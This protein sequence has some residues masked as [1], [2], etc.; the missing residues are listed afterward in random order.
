MK[1]IALFAVAVIVFF[2][3]TETAQSQTLSLQQILDQLEATPEKAGG[4]HYNYPFGDYSVAKPPKG[5]EP[6][7]ISH[8]G[9]H[10]ARYIT[11]AAKYDHA[12][13]LL[14]NGHAKGAL[15][16]EGEMLYSDYMAIY[17]LLQYHNGDLTVKGQEQHRELARRMIKA[18]P[19]L[20]KKDA[21]VDARASISPRAIVS[22]MSFCDEIHQ[23]RPRVSI[24]YSADYSELDVT[25]LK[26][27]D[28]DEDAYA[29]EFYSLFRNEYFGGSYAKAV[30][31]I[32][33]DAD[34]FFLRYLKDMDAVKE[35]GN[36]ADLFGELAEIAYNIQCL[37][38]EADLARYF[39]PAERF[40]SWENANIYAVLMFLDNP[41]SRGL[42]AARA[43]QLADD[44]IELAD[45]DLADGRTKARLRFGHDTIVGPLLGFL[46]VPGWGPLGADVSS[47]KYG[48]QSW[49][50]PMAANVQ[51]VFYR[52]RKNPSDI[53]VRVMYNEHDQI[54]P[55]EN[56]SLAPYYKWSDFKAHFLPE[57]ERARA[58]CHGFRS[59]NPVLSVEGGR[60]QGVKDGDDVLVYKGVPFAAPPV[61][62]RKGKPLQPVQPWEGI[63][64]ADKFPAAAMQDSFPKDDPLYYREFYTEGDPEFSEDCMYLNVWAPAS[65][66]GKPE[67]KAPVAVWIHGGAL[68]HGYSFEKEMDG[69]EWAKRGVILV[70]IP[71]RLGD[72][73]FG[74]DGHLGFQDQVSALRWVQKNIE[75][76]GGDPSNVTVFGQSAGAI[77]VKYLFT[78]PEAKDLFAKGIIQSGG[79]VNDMSA[80]PVLP[81]GTNGEDGYFVKAVESGCFDSKPIMIGYT[82]Q[83][84]G[85]LGKEST[86][87]FCDLVSP[88]THSAVYTYEFA[89][90]LPGEKEGE[91]DFGAFHTAELWY[92]F[93]TL[94]RAWR[95]F[96][97]ADYELSRRMLD[98]WTSFARS[99]N[100]GWK[101]YDIVEKHIEVFDI[102]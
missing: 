42:I 64:L 85:F 12:A 4:N 74:K 9:R 55:L 95:P 33:L 41:Y 53:L 31:E 78:N 19:S 35:C 10:G 27:M 20:F 102:Q 75:A 87:A 39:T 69:V 36:P 38:F 11:D 3:S 6:V 13:K 26:A 73:G 15:T 24:S 50:L 40:Q 83:D 16:A 57:I 101:A 56:Q 90:N 92:T 58:L 97:E 8:Y 86:V 29:Q 2:L 98:C 96:T 51:M 88:R 72:I 93:G 47:W 99:G 32:G 5:Y 44:M 76:F 61:G 23:Q 70:T 67:T 100:P 45:S 66:V 82:A 77:S 84:P 17:P 14:E 68:N 34:A 43:W 63:K 37:D 89:R 21:A 60:L 22:M 49:N 28:Q 94:G 46:G 80:F 52:K 91:I 71:Y 7:Y 25:T 1:R 54:L 59:G 62:E 48:F 65:A 81:K 18:Y 30:A 79:G